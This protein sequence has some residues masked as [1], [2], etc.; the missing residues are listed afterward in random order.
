MWMP[1]ARGVDWS[2]LVAS[3]MHSS[4]GSKQSGL[5]NRV[6]IEPVV[7]AIAGT[8]TIELGECW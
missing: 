3:E 6:W 1:V 7:Q 2:T 4:V 8:D 5:V